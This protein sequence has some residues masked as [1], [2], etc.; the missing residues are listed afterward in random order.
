MGRQAAVEALAGRLNALWL[1]LQIQLLAERERWALW[2][3]VAFGSGIAVYFTLQR[4]PPGWIGLLA[5]GFAALFALQARGRTWVMLGALALGAVGAGFGAAQLR[6]YLVA[7]PVLQEEH[8][9]ARIH[10]TVL[11]VEPRATGHRLRLGEVAVA[12]LDAN[13]TPAVVRV[14][15]SAGAPDILPGD[16]VRLLAVLSPPPEPA[17]PGAY[18]FARRAYFEQL[19]AVGF[20]LG[21]VERLARA[22]GAGPSAWDLWWAQRRQTIA[23]RVRAA[24]PGRAGTV[25]AAL[26]TGERSAIPE[27]VLQTMRDSGLAHLLAIS[28]LHVGLIAGL[29]FFAVRA[30]IALVPAVAVRVQA[31]KWAALAAALAGFCY[32]W[33]VG[34]TI[35]TQRAFLMLALVLLAVALDRSALTMRLVAWAAFVVLLLHPESLVSASFQMSFAAA[36]ALVA[37]YEGLRSHTFGRTSQRSI[38]MRLVLYAGSVALT[39]VIAILATGPFAV[40]HFNRLALYGLAANLVAVPLTAFWIMPAALV[41]FALMPLGLDGFG[42]TVMGWGIAGMLAVAETVADWPGAVAVLPSPSRAGLALIIA[43]GV[44][45]CLWQRRWRLWGL[46]AV[47]VGC[48]SVPWGPR[49]DVLVTGDARLIGVRAAS[50]ELWV[51]TQRRERFSRD[52]WMRRLGTQRVQTWPPWGQ[53]ESADLTCDPL[54]CLFRKNSLTAAL[55]RDGRALAEDCRMADVLVA[56]VP[57]ARIKC[58][59]P[60]IL[61][62]R[63]DLWRAGTHA[64]YLARDGPR[65]DTVRAH[66]GTRPWVRRRGRE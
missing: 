31:K 15:V 38:P 13:L 48:L 55:V 7:A 18:D 50:G 53:A 46:A 33:L 5:V 37:A 20:A 3:P 34:A 12:R 9:P 64:I 25:A 39:S 43:G 65:V 10:A 23:R 26:M 21:G 61:V 32:L 22:P 27:D 66:R 1:T 51:S 29:V 4:E 2:L 28:G 30:A 59:R 52:V 41:A 19:G 17:A 63:F 54:A 16:R 8:G 60:S 40:F 24:V 62:D 56:V 14:T 35:P 11:E 45:L 49:P 44:W 58:A 6:T 36:T 42:L 57:V 47:A